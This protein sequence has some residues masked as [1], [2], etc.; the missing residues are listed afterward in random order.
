M[1]MTKS[2]C[3]KCERRYIGC[4][5][6]CEKYHEYL[7]IHAAE[8][9]KINRAKYADCDVRTFLIEQGQRVKLAQHRE[10]MRE[11]RKG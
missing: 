1:S 3:F 9:D 5:A 2:P 10:Y 6:S 4:H 8:K 7:A 11:Y